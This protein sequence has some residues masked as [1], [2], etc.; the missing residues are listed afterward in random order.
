MLGDL[1]VGRKTLGSRCEADSE[2]STSQARART[3]YEVRF[4]SSG[5]ITPTVRPPHRGKNSGG[6]TYLSGTDLR[7]YRPSGSSSRFA[8]L[9][10]QGDRLTLPPLPLEPQK[11][12]AFA[13]SSKPYFLG[14]SNSVSIKAIS[15]YVVV[16]P[17]KT[18]TS[19]RVMRRTE[20]NERQRGLAHLML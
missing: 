9:A 12:H 16:R 19:P 20:R 8:I 2:A 13:A 10:A 11:V 15:E 6:A 4:R 1:V 5:A 14:K 7:R 18:R 3:A 17:Q